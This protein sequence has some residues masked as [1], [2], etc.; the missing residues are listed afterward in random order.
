MPSPLQ[1]LLVEDNAAD[2]DLILRELERAGFA[3]VCK[4]IETELAFLENLHA[5]LD[6]IISDYNLPQFSAPRAL[7]LLKQSGLAVPFIIVSG[8]IGEDAAVA[9][10]VFFRSEVAAKDQPLGFQLRE[11][12]IDGFP[13]Q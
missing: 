5:S 12:D 7:E 6:L 8:M 13:R 9:E 1:I 2:A 10:F 11:R 4:R 3:A